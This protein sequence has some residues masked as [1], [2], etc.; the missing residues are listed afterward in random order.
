VPGSYISHG[1]WQLLHKMMQHY[2]TENNYQNKI[3]KICP[4]MYKGRKTVYFVVVK[5]LV[6]VY[7]QCAC[8]AGEDLM[9]KGVNNEN[10]TVNH[11][12]E[13]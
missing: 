8:Q 5:M 9:I 12:A 11:V 2:K 6:I 7:W 3:R 13:N 10:S 4:C 1:D